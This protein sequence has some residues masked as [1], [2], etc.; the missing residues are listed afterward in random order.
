MNLN[1]LVA[2][3]EKAVVP[4]QGGKPP[5]PSS[6]PKQRSEAELRYFAAA[7]SATDIAAVTD[8][9]ERAKAKI[10]DATA[11]TYAEVYARQMKRAPDV[12]V[13][14][15]DLLKGVS[16][17][18]W[19]GTRAAI[20]HHLAKDAAAAKGRQEAAYKAGNL[21]EATQWAQEREV[22]A[23]VARDAMALD[24]PTER[25]PRQTKRLT[26]PTDP[27]WRAKVFEAATEAQKPGVAVLWATGCR[28]AEVES[29]VDVRAFEKDGKRYVCIDVPGAKVTKHSGQ[30]HRRI[31]IDAAS[32]P[33][34]ALL[35]VMGNTDRM[36]IKRGAAVLNNDFARIRKRLKATGGADWQVAPYSMRHQMSADAKVHFAETMPDEDA[37]VDAVA[38][39]LG[40]RVTRSQGRY[41]HPSQAKGG[42][43]LVGVRATHPVKDTKSEPPS[44]GVQPALRP[45]SDP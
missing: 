33:G 40:H 44:K 6:P 15:A 27:D 10:G 32:D 42:T 31:I 16:R 19:H 18:S 8:L 14:A 34:S 23:T 17:A 39:L 35:S 43:G 1:K 22:L 13:T 26:V 21:S 7:K 28:P 11:A 38:T 24:V 37:A 25:R 30:P 45:R 3:M 5:A 12:G 20:I 9:A 41:G 4:G 2:G 36:T 29:G